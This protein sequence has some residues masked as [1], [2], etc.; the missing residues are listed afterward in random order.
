M[1]EL[2]ETRVM[3]ALRQADGNKLTYAELKEKTKMR[4]GLVGYLEVMK[5]AGFID[6]T[7]DV[8]VMM[9]NETIVS[10]VNK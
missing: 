4:R 3:D 7:L 9:T 1:K 2:M 10:L 8:D 5:R 6:Y